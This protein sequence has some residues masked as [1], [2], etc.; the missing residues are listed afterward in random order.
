MIVSI[1]RAGRRSRDRLHSILLNN[2]NT[3]AMEMMVDRW[4]FLDV[5]VSDDLAPS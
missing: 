1:Q 4:R 3:E 2:S 5:H